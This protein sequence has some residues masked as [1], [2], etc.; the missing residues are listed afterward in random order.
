MNK[1]TVNKLNQM[2]KRFYEQVGE[3]FSQSRQ[4]PW[5]GWRRLL[6]MLEKIKTNNVR[7]LDIG[8]GNGRFGRF[9]MDT[10]DLQSRW[11]YTGLDNSQ[12]LL[13]EARRELSGMK[14]V[15][16]INMDV[17]EGDLLEI[18]AGQKFDVV[19]M[20]G[21][22]HHVPGFESRKVL[23]KTLSELLN[24]GGVLVVSAWQFDKSDRLKVAGERFGT[25][26]KRHF[27]I[28]GLEDGDYFLGWANKPGVYRYCHLTTKA[29]LERL[30]E[31]LG[32]S[33]IQEFE[34]DGKGGNLNLYSIYQK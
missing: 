15:G 24:P 19:V 7:V 29:E 20:F 10:N 12:G 13:A 31:E 16:L 3:E 6:P 14:N 27:E 28:D 34:A 23:M 32:A 9:L 22:L 2:N 25:E 8:C 33:K 26:V 18:A 30:T 4:S 1:T 11:Q 5:Q 21:V 17:I